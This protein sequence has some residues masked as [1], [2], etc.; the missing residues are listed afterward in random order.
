MRMP[1]ISTQQLEWLFGTFPECLCILNIDGQF[2]MVNPAFC[3]IS[4]YTETELIFAHYLTF[5]HPEDQEITCKALE[6]IQSGELPCVFENRFLFKDSEYKW[7]L[8]NCFIQ[9]Q[10]EL[11]YCSAR[12]IS[13]QKETEAKLLK[14][15][16][17]NRLLENSSRLNSIKMAEEE[18]FRWMDNIIENYTEGF[19]KLSKD[20]RVLA[21]NQ[22]ARVILNLP[23]DTIKESDFRSLFP[24]ERD[25]KLLKEAKRA[26]D[27][28][29]PVHFEEFYP[30]LGKWLEI[31]AYPYSE[32]VTLFFKDTTLRKKQELDLLRLAQDYKIL[33]ANNPLPMWAYDLDQLKILMANDAAL[34]LY[35]YSRQEF[36]N[37]NLYDLRPEAEHERLRNELKTRDVFKDLKISSEWQHQKKDGS[38]IYV[39]IASHMIKLNEGRARLIVVNNITERRKTQMKLLNQNIR[40]REIAQLSSHDLRG[41]VASILGL[42]SLFDETNQDVDLNNLIIENLKTSAKDLDKVIHAIVK[43]THEEGR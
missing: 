15:I 26:I 7:M 21:F 6:K 41:P 28:K 3:K 27:N 23:E 42:V 16:E 36:L 12:D 2:S 5:I 19:F 18:D 39:D 24:V 32:T 33:F 9:D 13:D 29:Q 20:W 17:E 25:H 8:W 1:D 35:G 38:I 40:L 10:N 37:L 34:N 30:H 31:S 11:I 43:M 14:T 22:M 4:G